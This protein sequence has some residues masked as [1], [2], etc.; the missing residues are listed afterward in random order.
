MFQGRSLAFGRQRSRARN[1]L[2]PVGERPIGPHVHFGDGADG[3]GLDVFV[4]Q[5]R[6]VGGMSLI[7]HLCLQLRLG[8]ALR[9]EPAA[10]LHRPRQRLLHVHVF[11]EI[12]RRERDERVRVIRRGNDHRVDVLLLREH[13]AVVGVALGL[14]QSAPAAAANS[15]ICVWIGR[16]FCCASVASARRLFAVFDLLRDVGEARVDE[17]PVHVAHGDQVLPDSACMLARPMPPTPTPAMLTRSLGAIRR[18]PPS[19]WRGTMVKAA[20]A[21]AALR[22]NCRRGSFISMPVAGGWEPSIYQTP[23]RDAARGSCRWRSS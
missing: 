5:P 3:A 22:T 6:I 19:T 12:H 16:S 9:G 21:S 18:G 11:A 23:G 4:D 15:L 8:R 17:G 13:L 1:A 10:F 20:A 14:R 2:R 7:A